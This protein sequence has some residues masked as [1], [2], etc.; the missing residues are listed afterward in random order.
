MKTLWKSIWLAAALASSAVGCGDDH[1]PTGT[2]QPTVHGHY[3]CTAQVQQTM[4][5]YLVNGNQLK[6][7]NPF[8]QTANGMRT[9]Y[10][11]GDR[12]LYG[13]WQIFTDTSDT[14]ALH[15]ELVVKVK[16]EPNK[17]TAIAECTSTIGNTVAMAWSPAVIDDTTIDILQDHMDQKEVTQ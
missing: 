14:S 17:V 7:T 4:L 13:T 11:T 6:L 9:T 8:G 2:V 15:L 1:M 5:S 3:T 10:G 16:F 12:P